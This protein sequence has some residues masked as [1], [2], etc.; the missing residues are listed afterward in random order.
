[1]KSEIRTERAPKAIGPYAQAV[2]A[3]DFL[4]V[5]GQ[6]PL[7][8]QTGAVVDGGIAPQTRRVLDNVKSVLEGANL[9]LEHV[10]KTTIF[11]ASMDDFATVNGIYADYF[12]GSILPA[13]AAVQVAKLPKEALVEIECIA[14]KGA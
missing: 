4:F 7:D 6:I 11:L 10:V 9:S 8:P 14:Y 13:R 2:L 12:N 3:G 5:S 1:M